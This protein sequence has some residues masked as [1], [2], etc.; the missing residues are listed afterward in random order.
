[1]CLSEDGKTHIFKRV[2]MENDVDNYKVGWFDD[3]VRSEESRKA[4]KFL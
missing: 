4:G 3:D 1:M 2:E